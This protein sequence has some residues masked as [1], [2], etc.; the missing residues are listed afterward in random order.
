MTRVLT[1]EEKEE[2]EESHVKMEASIG[3][4]QLQV[5]K[6]LEPSEAGKDKGGFPHSLWREHG[7]AD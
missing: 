2:R 3:V 6:C 1:R 5:K 4:M 7:P